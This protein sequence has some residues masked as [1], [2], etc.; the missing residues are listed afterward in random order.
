MKERLKKREKEKA[1]K[2]KRAKETIKKKV[3]QSPRAHAPHLQKHNGSFGSTLIVT[4][5]T[6]YAIMRG[7]KSR[8]Q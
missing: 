4:Y 6:Q 8:A 2:R 7:N 3:E 1:R 5:S